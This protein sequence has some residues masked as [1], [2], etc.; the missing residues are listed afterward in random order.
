LT[1]IGAARLMLEGAFETTAVPAT[2]SAAI[3]HTTSRRAVP[4]LLTAIAAAVLGGLG[5]W[6][7]MSARVPGPQPVLR[8]AL[9][10][11]ASIAPRGAGTGRHVLAISPQGTHLVYLAD[12]KLY[13][14]AL[15]RLDAPVAI[16]G[17][18]DAREPFFSPDGQWIGFQQQG[19]LKRIPLDGG[20]PIALGTSQNPWG[21]VGTPTG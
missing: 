21:S 17:T 3:A 1:D 20:L 18:E 6:R 14:R 12:N 16:R 5:V 19:Q 13:L 9:P 15:N 7:L 10:S 8:F 11:S 4:F 2:A